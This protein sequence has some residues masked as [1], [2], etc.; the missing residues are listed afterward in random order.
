VVRTFSDWNDPP[1]GFF[2]MDMVAHCGKSVAGSHAHSLVLT[3]IASG[4]TE[5]AAMVVREPT[6]ITVTVEEVRVRLPFPMLGLDVDDDSAFI[7]E[8]V[9]GY[10]KD[11]KLELTSL[12]RA[13]ERLSRQANG[14]IWKARGV[15]ATAALGKLHD[16]VRL[17]VNFFQPSFKPKSKM[18]EGA[19]ISKK[20]YLHR[21]LHSAVNALHGEISQQTAWVLLV[22]QH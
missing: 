17:Y 7:N 18:R 6:L 16:V 2:E 11:R 9:V 5:A 21:P 19:K 8:T 1:P 12:D 10:C 4:W 14:G 20:Y 13:K 22:A 3:D 15:A